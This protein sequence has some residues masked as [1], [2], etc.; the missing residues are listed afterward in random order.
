[1]TTENEIKM[2]TVAPRGARESQSKKQC[3]RRIADSR[4]RHVWKSTC[5]CATVGGA[6]VGDDVA[7][8]AAT[9]QVP[10]TFYDEHVGVPGCEACGAFM[11]YSHTEV[12]RPRPRRVE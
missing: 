4:V 7:V 9:R 12:L 5:R 3:W 11:V 8:V 2:V 10:P 6:M 1:M